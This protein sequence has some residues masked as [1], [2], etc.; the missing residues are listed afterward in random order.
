MS[1]TVKG[2]NGEV[3]TVVP[4]DFETYYD[5][6]HSL[7]KM[8]TT[9][10]VRSDEFQV[11][12][13]GIGWPDPENP[14]WVTGKDV[15]AYLQSIDWSD[16]AVLAHNAPFD[17]FILSQHYGI[18]PPYYLDTAAMSRGEFG[19][20]Y[21]HRLDDLATRLGHGKKLEGGLS[22]SLG[23]RNLTPE[24]EQ[25]LADYCV[26]DVTLTWKCWGT[27][28]LE[29]AYP[30][31]E[32]HIIHLT[33]KAFTDPKLLVD[34]ELCRQE[35]E[36]ETE[37]VSQLVEKAGVPASSLSSNPKFAQ[38][39]IDRGVEPPMKLSQRTGRYTYAF[40]KGDLEFQALMLDERVG[41]LIQARIAAKS[42]I[43]RTR[44]FRMIEHSRPTFPVMLIYCGAHTH[45]WTGGDKVN[46]QN[47]PSG[48]KGQSNALR[49]ALKA[50]PGYKFIK[51][52]SSQIECRVSAELAGEES[53]RTIFRE[54]KD[55]YVDLASDVFQQPVDKNEHPDLR[56]VGKAGELSLQFGVGWRKFAYMVRAG[57]NGPPVD[58]SDEIAQRAVDTYRRKRA[59]VVSAWDR[60]NDMLRWMAQTTEIKGHRE[61]PFETEP[62]NR[63]FIFAFENDRIM[64]PNY[65]W[66]HYPF[67]TSQLDDSG[68]EQ[69]FFWG[70]NGW[71]S[72]YAAKVWE[73]IVQSVARTIVAQQ[74]VEVAK[75]FPD[76]VLLVHDEVD[77]LVPEDQAE[78]ARDY[79]LECFR[80]PPWW[81]P[82]IPLDGEAYIW[83]NYGGEP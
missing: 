77:F 74:A 61:E 10:Y 22:P 11:H 19:M 24:I 48:R 82:D 41:D 17:G 2:L 33:T 29:R 73:N 75:R 8:T 62:R 43:N 15:D 5:K 34:H 54:G 50:P 3:L 40:S 70:R 71:T 68:R 30:E 36:N 79:A 52:D 42:T 49:R 83:S 28:Y 56:Q 12:G 7:R 13:I 55:P 80:T 14:I 37:R 45:R 4:L 78:E 25:L 27:L 63:E 58:I 53:L 26:Q 21:T 23:V 51:A 47:L 6:D 44:P 16:K 57:A 64:M 35:A 72:T 67:L 65:L 9:T 69:F 32:L 66:L 1:K 38:L 46:P 60:I 18:I 39:L 20:M 81:L 31:N 59:R 76:I